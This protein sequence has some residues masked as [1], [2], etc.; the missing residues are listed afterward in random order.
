MMYCN[1]TA[2]NGPKIGERLMRKPELGHD[3]I[4]DP[5]PCTVVYVV[6]TERCKNTR[7]PL[8]T[9]GKS[10]V[11]WYNVCKQIRKF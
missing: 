1:G 2:V 3:N 5:I 10:R 7:E 6:L 8:K 9:L 11:T 4:P